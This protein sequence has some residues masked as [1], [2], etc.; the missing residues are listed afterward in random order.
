ML[1]ALQLPRRLERRKADAIKVESRVTAGD[2]S[3]IRVY[4][5]I[6][7]QTPVATFDR[8][9]KGLVPVGD[10]YLVASEDIPEV[11]QDYVP[12]TYHLMF[13]QK[14]KKRFGLWSTGSEVSTLTPADA[15]GPTVQSTNAG[16]HKIVDPTL[17]PLVGSR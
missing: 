6:I 9:L 8:D 11:P 12:C 7:I 14:I 1:P 2:L 15:S 16:T 13:S 17:K 10:P 4:K 3:H 5:P